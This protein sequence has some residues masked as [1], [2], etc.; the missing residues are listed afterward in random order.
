M[1][2]IWTLKCG[3]LYQKCRLLF[4]MKDQ[5]KFSLVSIVSLEWPLPSLELDMG[6]MQLQRIPA[7]PAIS[8]KI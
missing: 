4:S 5:V 1:E 3:N 6:H 2:G 8:Q 7:L